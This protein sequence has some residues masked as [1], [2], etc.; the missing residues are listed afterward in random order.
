MVTKT[1]NPD[2]TRR[3]ILDA[4]VAE[5]AAVG[6]A[7]ARIDAIAAAAGVN[8]RMLYHY[9]ASKDGLFAAVLG[10]QLG[11][12]RSDPPP[13]SLTER[14]AAVSDRP[15]WIRLLMWEALA[16]DDRR[17][18]LETP[19]GA[20]RPDRHPNGL[21]AS[22]LE[23]AFTVLSLCPFAFPQ[24]TRLITG[25]SPTD[26]EFAASWSAFLAALETRIER[27]VEVIEAPKPRFR[28]AA[29]V[30]ESPPP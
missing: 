13:T 2:R 1:R 12:T 26:R 19:E 18:V 20:R 16:G 4:A 25:A 14:Y 6:P 10:D 23:L 3:A 29:S 8:K 15:E 9:F 24:L 27:K 21:D 28:L 30:T 17:G 22:H 7:G 5:F 11:L